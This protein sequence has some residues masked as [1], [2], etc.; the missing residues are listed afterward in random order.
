MALQNR[1]EQG[2]I[3]GTRPC[4]IVLQPCITDMDAD[5]PSFYNVIDNRVRCRE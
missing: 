2:R 1:C 3:E 4:R 5:W